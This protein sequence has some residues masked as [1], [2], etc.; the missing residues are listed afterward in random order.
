M[1]W[2]DVN[3]PVPLY[4]PPRNLTQHSVLKLPLLGTLRIA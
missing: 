2:A 3:T 4:S 1:G